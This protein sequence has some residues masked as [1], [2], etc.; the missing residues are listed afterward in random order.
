[1]GVKEQ[2]SIMYGVQNVESGSR[3][4]EHRVTLMHTTPEP[5]DILNTG[6][7]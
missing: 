5:K 1:M 3:H 2:M 7:N 4:P 6:R